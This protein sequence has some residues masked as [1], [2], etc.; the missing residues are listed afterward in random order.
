MLNYAGKISHLSWCNGGE[1]EGFRVQFLL[2]TMKKSTRIS[3]VKQL[4][5][6][7]EEN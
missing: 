5:T 2:P 3:Q 1:W 7:A 6:M 4:K